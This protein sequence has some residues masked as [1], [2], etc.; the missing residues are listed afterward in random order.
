MYEDGEIEQSEEWA[1]RKAILL[2][3]ETYDENNDEQTFFQEGKA[4]KQIIKCLPRIFK[5]GKWILQT[6]QQPATKNSPRKASKTKPSDK[7]LSAPVFNT[8]RTYIVDSGASFHIVD[9]STLSA[10]ERK[11][12]LKIKKPILTSTANG[13]IELTESCTIY[14]R[15]L[16][17]HLPAYVHKGTVAILSLGL[18]CQDLGFT[19]EWK[20]NA[21]PT[22]TKGDHKITCEPHFNVPFIYAGSKKSAAPERFQKGGSD[23]DEKSA[24]EVIAEEMKGAADLIPP[25]PSPPVDGAGGPVLRP[26]GRGKQRR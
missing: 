14:V 25:P 9:G 23:S 17:M 26:P 2:R 10:K 12:L 13:E 22:L 16:G 7:G 21:S 4:V 19:Y 24:K 3:D 20:P 11:T 6:P 18:L 1:R 8:S 5:N 15:E